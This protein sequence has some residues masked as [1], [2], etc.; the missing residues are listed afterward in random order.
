MAFQ[1]HFA[2][3]FQRQGADHIRNRQA[4]LVQQ[5]FQLAADAAAGQGGD[6]R[7]GHAFGQAGVRPARQR[8]GRPAGQHHGV[9]QQGGRPIDLRIDRGRKT[10][11]QHVQRARV[12]VFDQ[13]FVR[14]DL[15]RERDARIGL[16]KARRRLGHR[17]AGKHG[18]TTHRQAAFVAARQRG[19]I[20][21]GLAKARQQLARMPA[22]GFAQRR[23]TGAAGRALEQPRTHQF[24]D[25]G[26]GPR[27][28]R[29]RAVQLRGRLGQVAQLGHRQ[30]DFQM[31][32]AEF[33][34][35]G[36]HGGGSGRAVKGNPPIIPPRRGLGNAGFRYSAWPWDTTRW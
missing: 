11:D 16:A 22:H 14:A 8:M 33:S 10:A 6:P 36:R 23:A 17:P 3:E 35:E 19:Q 32:G 26:D 2:A 31:P 4:G 9:F 13:A 7:I 1:Q 20:D 34:F 21:L 12:Q 28:A 29:L 5:H 15:K 18:K 25:F 27:Q 30:H 24:L